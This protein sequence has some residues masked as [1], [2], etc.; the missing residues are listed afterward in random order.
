MFESRI[1][2]TKDLVIKKRK[3]KVRT[4]K[5]NKTYQDIDSL[6]EGETLE[7]VVPE[8]KGLLVRSAI[9]QKYK[10]D[11]SILIQKRGN[12]IYISKMKG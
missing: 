11:N 12:I 3:T 2:S 8:E 5:Y 7:L 6:I 1:V 9:E 10:D 4:P